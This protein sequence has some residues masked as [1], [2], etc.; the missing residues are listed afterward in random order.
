MILWQNE[1][2]KGWI[3]IIV[4]YHPCRYLNFH[5]QVY[6]NMLKSSL[7]AL[8]F[9]LWS[10]AFTIPSLMAHLKSRHQIHYLVHY[11]DPT[12][13]AAASLIFK[14]EE[15]DGDFSNDLT[16]PPLQSKKGKPIPTPSMRIAKEYPRAQKGPLTIWPTTSEEI[17]TCKFLLPSPI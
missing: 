10:V 6:A 4:F 7:V 16:I 11:I 12:S 8:W 3:F 15:L 14:R 2:Q 5:Y 13:E 17:S 1:Y 9:A